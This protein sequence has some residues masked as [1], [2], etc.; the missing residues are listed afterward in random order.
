[1]LYSWCWKIVKSLNHVIED[2][3][4]VCGLKY[5]LLSVSQNY[6]KGNEVKS[7]SDMCTITSLKIGSVILRA[8]RCKN[9]YVADLDSVPEYE[10]TCLRAQSGM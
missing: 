9:M 2:V 6:D 5:S 3:Y 10:L 4:Y 1:M 8:K 7:V